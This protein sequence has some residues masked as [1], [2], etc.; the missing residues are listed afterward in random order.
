MKSS[1]Q[2]NAP[3]SSSSPRKAWSGSLLKPHTILGSIASHN[4][5]FKPQGAIT[6]FFRDAIGRDRNRCFL[7]LL[8]ALFFS[9][10]TLRDV[11]KARGA[12]MIGY[13]EIEEQWLLGNDTP[14]SA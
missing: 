9:V 1:H 13:P 11:N 6:P 3:P 5:T 12:E 14:M 2:S 10:G 7:G 8:S 4:T